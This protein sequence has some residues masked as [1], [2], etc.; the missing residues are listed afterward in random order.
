M[1][2]K[3]EMFDNAVVKL[4]FLGKEDIDFNKAIAD[5]DKKIVDDKNA[6]VAKVVADKAKDASK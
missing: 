3:K 5:L 4:D 6:E 1:S 2:D